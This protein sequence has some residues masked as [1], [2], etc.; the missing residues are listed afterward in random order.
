MALTAEQKRAIADTLRAAYKTVG[1][2]GYDMKKCWGRDTAGRI[3]GTVDL[4]CLRGGGK[5]IGAKIRELW[6]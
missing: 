1:K 3:T 5:A 6:K 2:T 4:D